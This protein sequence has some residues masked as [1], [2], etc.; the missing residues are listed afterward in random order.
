QIGFRMGS[1]VVPI[2]PGAVLFD[3][4]VGD[5]KI[6]PDAEAGYQASRSAKSGPVAEGNVGAGAVATVGKLLGMKRAMKSGL[7]TYG[8]RIG[9]TSLTV[10]ALVAVNAVGDV[11]DHKTGTILAGT[12][13]SDGKTLAGSMKLLESGHG[14]PAQRGTNSSIGIVATNA[15]F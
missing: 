3:L 6:R 7:G 2:V 8:I 9:S 15:A 14:I 13:A 5:P 11:I 1:V 10:G 12:R 4:S